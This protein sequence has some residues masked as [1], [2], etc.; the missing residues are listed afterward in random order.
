MM[1]YLV[2]VCN[3]IVFEK[4]QYDHF[5]YF[6]VKTRCLE[7][8]RLMACVIKI[9]I[10]TARSKWRIEGLGLS[11]I[12]FVFTCQ[13]SICKIYTNIVSSCTWSNGA[14]Y[15]SVKLY[16]YLH[17]VNQWGGQTDDRPLTVAVRLDKCNSFTYFKYTF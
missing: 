6:I 14:G 16:M 7:K 10:S 11:C 17:F 1:Y 9:Y 2:I 3:T 12:Y 15:N 13:P 4:Y 8:E 5:G